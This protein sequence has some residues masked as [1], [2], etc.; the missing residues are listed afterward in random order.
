MQVLETVF[1][2]FSMLGGLA[3]FLFSMKLMGDA[4]ETVSGNEMKRLFEKV[5]NNRFKGFAIGLTVTAVIQSSAATSVMIVGLVNVGCMTL[6]QATPILLGAVVGTTVTAQISSLS[7]FDITAIMSLVAAVGAVFYLF[8]KNDK[9]RHIGAIALGLGMLFIGLALMCDSMKIIAFDENGDPTMFARAIMSFEDPLLCVISMMLLT[10]ILQSSSAS[11]SIMVVLGTAGVLVNPY[12]AMFMVLGS[13]I[14]TTVTALLASIGTSP[15]A[16]RTA[17]IN[18]L[19]NFFGTIIWFFVL[20]VAQ[21][22]IASF[23]MSFSGSMARFIANY[24]TF[25]NLMVGLFMLAFIKPI[26]KLSEL[27]IKDDKKTNDSN[28]V[29]KLHYLDD[30]IFKTPSL[31]VAQSLAEVKSMADTSFDNLM[32]SIDMLMSLDDSNVNKIKRNEEAINFLNLEITNY[33]VKFSSLDLSEKDDHI[34]GSL[35]HVVTDIE[36]I[37][38]YAENVMDFA[39]DMIK[40]GQNF[41]PAALSDMDELKGYLDKLYHDSV[42]AFMKRDRNVL[43]SVDETEKK[44]DDMKAKMGHMH[45]KRL[46]NGE[47]TPEVGAIYLSMASQLERVADH[48]TNIAYSIIPFKEKMEIG[49]IKVK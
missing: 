31:A 24:H 27:M 25:S 41:S 43:K 28:D 36:R 6:I 17:L 5:T 14:G 13:H 37:G 45:V 40:K 38:D 29:K 12:S 10:A 23:V 8:V 20:L 39:I 26:T 32:M 2:I 34:I 42:D 19:V 33:L 16:R 35:F 3:I 21:K 7:A 22:P 4:L 18:F 11:T 15:N 47:C 30:L 1:S 49:D 46:N 44:V 9:M 48:M